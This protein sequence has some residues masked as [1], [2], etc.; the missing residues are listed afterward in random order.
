[1]RGSSSF[2]TTDGRKYSYVLPD[3]LAPIIHKKGSFLT[4]VIVLYYG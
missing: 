1:M 4:Q 2:S 3:L